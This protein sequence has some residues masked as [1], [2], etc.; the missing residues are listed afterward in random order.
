MGTGSPLRTGG[1]LSNDDAD[2]NE[3]IE[4][5]GLLSTKP[6]RDVGTRLVGTVGREPS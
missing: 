2:D 1:S 4:L 6:T 3:D 5:Q